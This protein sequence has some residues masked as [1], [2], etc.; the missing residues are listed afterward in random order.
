MAE[1]APNNR[2][3]KIVVAVDKFKGTITAPQ[4]AQAIKEGLERALP[5]ATFH[6]FPM[7]DGGD[8]SLSV[9]ESAV[10]GERIYAEATN[11]LGE[12]ISAPFLM[13][14]NRAFVEMAQISGLALIPPAGRDILR[15]STYGLGELIRYAIEVQHAQKVVVAIGGSATNDGGIGMLEALGF[16]YDP[17]NNTLDSSYVE[18]ITPHLW[19]TEIEVA[20]D[21]ENPLLGPNGATAIYGRQKG[22]TDETIPVLEE[23]L[24]LWG[25]AVAQWRQLPFEELTQYPGAGAAGGVGF[26]LHGVL[27][28]RILQGWRVFTDMMGVEGEIA[29]ADLVVTGE[30]KFDGQSLEG[31]LPLGIAQ[32]CAQYRKPLWLLC[33]RNAVSEEIYRS[34]GICRVMSVASLFPK[35]P[36]SD[37]AEKLKVAAYKI[38]TTI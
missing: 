9:V 10:G 1:I 22:A 35:D 34:H 3:R 14:G 33:G 16:K 28:A 38:V 37:A 29:S 23:R 8:G 27:Q 13:L 7:A 21:V 11:P 30:G 26:A 19:D 6:L 12:K 18:K 31:K 25:E 36:M 20:C 2:Y 17:A 24:R 32:L 5:E 4:A 15:A